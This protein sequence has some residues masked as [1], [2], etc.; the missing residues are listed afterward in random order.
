ALEDTKSEHA[1]EALDEALTPGMIRLEYHLGIACR[2][3]AIALLRQL[4]AQLGVVVDGTVVDNGQ[5]E[6]RVDHRL[7]GVVAEIDDAQSAVSERRA[8]VGDLAA[9]VRPT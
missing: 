6:L 4:S 5:A 1:V 9:R 3:E 7:L 8:T 2:E